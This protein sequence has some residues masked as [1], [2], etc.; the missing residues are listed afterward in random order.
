MRSFSPPHYEGE[1][2]V[3]VAQGL[4]P[5]FDI[6]EHPE[7]F[8]LLINYKFLGGIIKDSGLIKDRPDCNTL[9]RLA[10]LAESVGEVDL[11]RR[12]IFRLKLPFYKTQRADEETTRHVYENTTTG[13]VL[14]EILLS[15]VGYPQCHI[16]AT[17]FNDPDSKVHKPWPTAMMGEMLMKYNYRVSRARQR[18]PHKRPNRGPNKPKIRVAPSVPKEDTQTLSMEFE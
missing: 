18:I 6:E 8:S 13:H 17:L 3:F 9:L 16:V 1:V 10:V 7:V 12:A 14:R 15:R 2:E 4:L 11:M 5:E